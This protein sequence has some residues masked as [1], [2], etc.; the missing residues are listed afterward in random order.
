[1][2]G[3]PHGLRILPERA[4][5]ELVLTRFPCLVTR[6]EFRFAQL[7]I[8]RAFLR[9]DRDHVAVAQQCDRAADRRLRPDMADAAAARAARAPATGAQRIF[10]A[11]ALAVDR[12]G[13]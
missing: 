8:E 10:R 7:D 13:R 5:L 11:L 2:R 9:V 1:F 4:G 3:G 6:G 12:S